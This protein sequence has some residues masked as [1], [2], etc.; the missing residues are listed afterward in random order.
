MR[1][2]VGGGWGSLILV[3]G[4]ILFGGCGY[5]PLG[6]GP[7]SRGE[8]VFVEAITN[9]TLR[10]GIQTVVSAAILRQ[11]R[12]QGILRSPETGPPDLILSGAVT[13]Y[14][15]QAI[16]FDRLQPDV[17]RRFRVRVTLFAT[18]TARSDGAV[19]LKEAITGEAFYTAGVGAVGTR[20]AE[21]DA[22]QR[23]AQDLA[24]QVVARLLEEW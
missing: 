13:T 11:L 18:L 21:D 6:S 22:L 23:A 10:P 20:N 15:N 2:G 7:P 8:R 3:A 12:L 4:A 5:Q 24:S 16:G 17:G 19:R 9:G 1:M 14:V